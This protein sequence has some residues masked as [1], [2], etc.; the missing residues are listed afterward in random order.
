M[1][2]SWKQT[3]TSFEYP[4]ATTTSPKKKTEQKKSSNVSTSSINRIAVSFVQPLACNDPF[5]QERAD[6]LRSSAGGSKKRRKGFN[7]RVGGEGSNVDDMEPVLCLTSSHRVALV[8]RGGGGTSGLIESKPRCY[9]SRP[10]MG[11]S[12]VV[13]SASGDSTNATSDVSFTGMTSSGAQYDPT[14]NLVYGI[15]NGGA[16]IA[17]WTATSSS[18]LQGPDDDSQMGGKRGDEF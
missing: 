11:S 14:S 3:R 16:E 15:R 2:T 6:P 13:A 17:V 9:V 7:D 5:Y 1:L 10:G 18:I 4:L 8:G 12:F